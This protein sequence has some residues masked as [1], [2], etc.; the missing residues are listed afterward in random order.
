MKCPSC[1]VDNPPEDIYCECGYHLKGKS[2]SPTKTKKCPN[3][4]CN[5]KSQPEDIYC[6]GCGYELRTEEIG[7]EILEPKQTA[8]YDNPH[9]RQ[10]P[11]TPETVK[12]ENLHYQQPS[13][14]LKTKKPFYKTLWFCISVS[15][16]V[17]II[18]MQVTDT[19]RTKGAVGY[20]IVETK[21]IGTRSNNRMMYK[22]VVDPAITREQVKPTARKII[23]IITSKDKS[24]DEI[25]L[26]LYSEISVIGEAYDI[27]MIDWGYPEN[28]GKFEFN[29]K[30]EFGEYII[31]RAKS[32]TLF[33]LTEQTRR[34]IFREMILAEDR[35]YAEEPNAT[36]YRL[37]DKYK[38][39]MRQKYNITE[40]TQREIELEAMRENWPEE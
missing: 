28:E 27:A 11:V 23:K 25:T 5:F 31:Q 34:E 20:D 35:A 9:Y 13:V 30:E 19:L 6:G 2:E 39:E 21:F 38:Q 40:A 12:D 33:G 8:K 32:E 14:M 18:I 16:I 3:S 37:E 15:I 26:Y 7:K 22:V 36:T 4:N 10:P 17:I 29:I 24:I 1:G